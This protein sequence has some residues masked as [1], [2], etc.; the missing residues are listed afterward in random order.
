MGYRRLWLSGTATS[1]DNPSLLFPDNRVSS[2]K[3]YEIPVYWHFEAYGYRRMQ[4]ALRQQGMVVN[5]KKLRRLMREHDLQPRRR[6][7]YVATTDGDHDLSIFPKLAKEIVPDGPD[8][9]WV[10][11]I[12]YVAM[13]AGFAYVA[14]ILDAWSR[15]VVGYA[16]ARSIDVRLTLAALQ[17][18]IEKRRPPPGCIHHTD[19]GS[20]YAAGRYRQM[21][22]QRGF[23]GSMG[24]RAIPATT[25]RRRAS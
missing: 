21:L 8:Q 19:R 15:M 20:Q 16:I 18:A 22:A 23:V 14:V 11:D 9:L 2:G 13:P 10:A 4:A 6:R 25:Q 24:S 5:H 12:T 3:I 1:S 7:R 17:S